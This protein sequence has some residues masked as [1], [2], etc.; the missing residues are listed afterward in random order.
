MILCSKIAFLNVLTQ[1]MDYDTLLGSTY[2]TPD[3]GI[4]AQSRG[5]AVN[6]GETYK[7]DE[8]TGALVQETTNL[9][10][11]TMTQFNIYSYCPTLDPLVF[12]NHIA[13]DVAGANT[14][15]EIFI[16]SLKQDESLLAV[17]KWFVKQVPDNDASMRI[18]MYENHKTLWKYGAIIAD[19]MSSMFGFDVIYI[20]RI[21]NP[22]IPGN[23]MYSGNAENAKQ[24]IEYLSK[25]E[26]EEQF[27]NVNTLFGSGELGSDE[28]LNNLNTLLYDKNFPE[29]LR[30]YQTLF[31]NEPLPA[32]N[33]T[34]SRM[35]EIITG[36]LIDRN[37]HIFENDAYVDD[38]DDVP[39][40]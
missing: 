19:Y 33:Y 38:D 10:G 4:M 32:G 3:A 5:R 34:E 15:E 17:Y 22:N 7:F 18:L 31:P 14:Q 21:Y 9:S 20:D 26:I 40:N 29:L 28:P 25:K 24:L 2:Y 36:K 8:A 1:L 35:R 11:S 13:F 12:S 39:F 6:L 27:N 23:K 37:R 30:I 16:N